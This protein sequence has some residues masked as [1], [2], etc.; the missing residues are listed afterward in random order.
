[1]VT[2]VPALSE[3][4]IFMVQLENG[5]GAVESVEVGSLDGYERIA[6]QWSGPG[7][8]QI[9]AREFGAAYGSAGHVWSGSDLSGGTGQLVRL[10]DLDALNPNIAEI[11]TYPVSQ[12]EREGTVSISVEAEVTDANCGRDIAA[13]SIELR[14]RGSLRTRDLVLTMPDCSAVGDFLVLNNLV[15]DLK[16]ASR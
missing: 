7:G 13:Q 12:T 15:D 6:L 14:E 11:Y 8:F 4:A 2:T 3:T 10:G 16:I 5:S 9:H 1:V